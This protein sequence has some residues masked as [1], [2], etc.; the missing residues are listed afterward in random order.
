MRAQFTSRKTGWNQMSKVLSIIVAVLVVMLLLGSMVFLINKKHTQIHPFAAPQASKTLPVAWSSG[1]YM[2]TRK[3]WQTSRISKA[4]IQTHKVLWEYAV[5]GIYAS[6]YPTVYSNTVYYSAYN[7]DMSQNT[8]YALDADNGMLR[9][10]A[11]LSGRTDQSGYL[12]Q[13][14][15]SQGMLY[16][17][18]ESRGTVTA[19]DANTGKV[20][21]T[22]DGPGV[23][24]Y[25]SN[26][27]LAVSKSVVYGIIA[28]MLFTLSADTGKEIRN[29]VQIDQNKT[30]LNIEAVHD[31][32]YATACLT[33][34]LTGGKADSYIYAFD[35]KQGTQQ[36]LYHSA[37]LIFKSV[38]SEGDWSTS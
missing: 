14:L 21:W 3:N 20:R 35:A 4:D 31:V 25:A 19:L 13:P 9:W 5:E 23:A 18:A 12:S 37:T 15:Y 36:W 27:Q 34:A 11:T 24:A 38:F 26:G 10:K 17:M 7:Y 8:V 16:I 6:S 1:I 2:V 32:L 22:Y 30:F 28:N 33:S 29:V